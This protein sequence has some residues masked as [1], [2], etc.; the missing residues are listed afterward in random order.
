MKKL[1]N[2]KGKNLLFLNRKNFQNLLDDIDFVETFEIKKIYPNKV[3]VEVIE[4]EPIGVYINEQGKRYLL[5]KNNRLIKNYENSFTNL[6]EVNGEGAIENFSNFYKT[7]EN[8]KFNLNLVKKYNYYATRRWDV[9]LNDNKLIKLPPEN[10]NESLEKFAEIYEKSEFN[11]FKI[12][13]FRIK[14]ELIMR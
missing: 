7:I 9:L 5:L 14:N 2:I 3:R 4:L 11:K 12:F 10:Y 6:P 8:S 1:N 13:D